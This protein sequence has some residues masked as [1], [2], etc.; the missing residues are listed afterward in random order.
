MNK[1][2]IFTRSILC[3]F[4]IDEKLDNEIIKELEKQEKQKL[5]LKYSNQG[6]FHSDFIDNEFICKKI[7]QKSYE[8]ITNNYKLK[9]KTNFNLANLWINKNRKYDYNN[10]HI[11]PGSNFS[12]VYY[13]NVSKKNGELVFLENDK[14]SMSDLFFFIDSDE[15]CSN[16]ELKPKKNMFLIFPSTFN[17]MVN[18]HYEDMSRISVSFNIKLNNG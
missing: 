2:N 14:G 9:I 7:L 6:G 1:I 16:F 8:L 11:H 4:L 3:D 13:L 12:G 5:K 15:F 18:P 17:H 10:F